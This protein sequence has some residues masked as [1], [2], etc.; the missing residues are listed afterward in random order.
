MPAQDKARPE[1]FD[2]DSVREQWDH[3][4]EGWNHSQRAGL[5]T[6]RTS[7]H[8]PALVK[9]VGDVDGKELLDLGCGEGYFSREMAQRGATVTGIDLS[10]NQL[11]HAAAHESEKPLGITFREMNASDLAEEFGEEAFDVVTA[12]MSLMDMPEPDRAIS[13]AADVLKPGGRLV[14]SITHPCFQTP[15]REWHR[16]EVGNKLALKVSD[17]FASGPLE[18]N[19]VAVSDLYDLAT[20]QFHATLTQWFRWITAAGLRVHN[21]DE[22][23]PTEEA[24][25]QHPDL[26]DA[27]M[28]AYFLLFDARKP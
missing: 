8:G 13:A 1:R 7:L 2:A 22:P 17:Y 6:Y 3:N 28:V 20:T 18:L 24:L 14:F 27:E 4:A 5:D 15:Y 9:L 19:F 11:Q 21:I 23:R 25:K 26:I 10:P 12:C 16:D